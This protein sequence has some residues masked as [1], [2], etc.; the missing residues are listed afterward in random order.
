MLSRNYS[1]KISFI[2]FFPHF[3]TNAPGLEYQTLSLCLKPGYGLLSVV[4]LGC[5]CNCRRAL[6]GG[7]K[8]HLFAGHVRARRPVCA[9]D[10]RR[11]PLWT[12]RPPAW[13]KRPSARHAAVPGLCRVWLG[14]RAL[15]ILRTVVAWIH[16]PRVFSHVSAAQT[17]TSLPHQTQVGTLST[18]IA[19]C[20]SSQR[21]I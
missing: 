10:P 11:L 9:A 14:R 19:N 17:A 12:L 21:R 13:I 6:W 18:A 5:V 15:A 2:T 16:P 3:F 4:W 7:S 8:W 1:E 20:I